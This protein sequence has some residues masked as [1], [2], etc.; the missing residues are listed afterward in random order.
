[1]KC[2]ALVG[3][4][5]LRLLNARLR[6]NR[7]LRARKCQVTKGRV[8]WQSAADEEAAAPPVPLLTQRWGRTPHV[9]N[10]A[11]AEVQTVGKH[12]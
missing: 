3:T 9:A 10:G 5:I 2:A 7:P 1:M 12:F 4:E 11:P 6:S 8:S